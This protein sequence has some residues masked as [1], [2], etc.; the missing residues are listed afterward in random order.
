VTGGAANA[1]RVAAGH[2]A[3]EFKKMAEEEGYSPRHMFNANNT[4]YHTN[5]NIYLACK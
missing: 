1:Y 4:I 3:P 2:F 5:S